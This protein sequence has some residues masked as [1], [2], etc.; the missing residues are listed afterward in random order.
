[1]FPLNKRHMIKRTNINF[2]PV[3]HQACVKE[4]QHKEA[5]M[6]Q[7]KGDSP[8]PQTKQGSISL[9]LPPKMS[10]DTDQSRRV[11]FENKLS[12]GGLRQKAK[13]QVKLHLTLS[14]G[15]QKCHLSKRDNSYIFISHQHIVQNGTSSEYELPLEWTY[16]L[17]Q[18]FR[19]KL[20]R[21]CVHFNGP[22]LAWWP[23]DISRGSS[24]RLSTVGAR[25]CVCQSGPVSPFNT[26][27]V[28]QA[29]PSTPQGSLEYP[30]NHWLRGIGL[31]A[32]AAA[33]QRVNGGGQ[34]LSKLKVKIKIR[35]QQL[36]TM[37]IR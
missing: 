27:D 23:C 31:P 6:Q 37:W 19:S 3:L 17:S 4:F 26:H 10:G 11:T 21:S 18:C 16:K 2:L 8:W 28:G 12:V 13:M 34:T 20:Q 30:A 15:Q 14:S 9:K 32:E 24:L 36:E 5:P 7:G 22:S 25:L 33:A 35:L 29:L 1:M